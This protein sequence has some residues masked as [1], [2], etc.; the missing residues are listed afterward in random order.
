MSYNGLGD[1]QNA[2]TVADPDW[3]DVFAIRDLFNKPGAARA[4]D[5]HAMMRLVK[6]IKRAAREASETRLAAFYKIVPGP[7]P[8]VLG[9]ASL[10]PADFKESFKAKLFDDLR[11]VFYPPPYITSTDGYCIYMPTIDRCHPPYQRC[12]S[13]K[14]EL[15]QEST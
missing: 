9:G 15:E 1:G 14:S 4:Y 2:A 7:I 10:S 12:P 6:D 8:A 5:P 13:R 11:Q 3:K